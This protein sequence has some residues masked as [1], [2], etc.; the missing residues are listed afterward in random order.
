MSRNFPKD[1]LIFPTLFRST[2][3]QKAEG[4]I[5]QPTRRKPSRTTGTSGGRVEREGSQDTWDEWER[6]TSVQVEAY[7]GTLRF[8]NMESRW[9]VPWRAHQ[10]TVILVQAF[11]ARVSTSALMLSTMGWRVRANPN[12]PNGSPCCTPQQ[13]WM[14]SL[15]KWR[16]GW[17]E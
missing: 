11:K 9:E 16:K 6:L 1:F 13:L 3:S 17:P 12:G 14:M 8:H 4:P 10:G 7:W 15:P 2:S 5:G